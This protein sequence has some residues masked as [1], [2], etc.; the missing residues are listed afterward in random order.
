MKW[1]AIIII[2]SATARAA[3]TN[4]PSVLTRAG[5]PEKTGAVTVEKFKV[6]AEKKKDKDGKK[7]TREFPLMFSIAQRAQKAKA[8]KDENQRERKAK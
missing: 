4:W 3:Q 5:K 8:E 7:E 2:L 1:L 6:K